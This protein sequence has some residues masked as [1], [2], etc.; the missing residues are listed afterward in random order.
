[1]EA[2]L[3]FHRSQKVEWSVSDAAQ[4]LFIPESLTADLLNRLSEAGFLAAELEGNRSVFRYA[5]VSASHA[6]IVDRLAKLYSKE[7]IA[8]T[9]LI[10]S[11]AGTRI[12]QFA[13][14]FKLKKE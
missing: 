13:D 8:V 11:K 4:K 5:P 7:L 6:E 9:Q 10:H 14:A 2:L 1:M 12:Q 3:L